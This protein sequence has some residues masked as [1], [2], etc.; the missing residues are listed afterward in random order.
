[1]DHSKIS[2]NR[3]RINVKLI[4]GTCTTLAITSGI[5]YPFFAEYVVLLGGDA[6]A[7]GLFFAVR[8]LFCA[9]ALIP[10]GYLADT[11]GRK[12][13]IV[14][15]TT[16]LGLVCFAYALVPSW[17][18]L[19]VLAAFEGLTYMYFPALT[20]LLM[21][22]APTGKVYETLATY[23]A[24]VHAPYTLMPVVGGVLR[25]AYGITGIR[26]GL[27]LFFFSALC[28]AF[29]RLRLRETVPR[30]RLPKLREVVGS[31][32]DIVPVLKKMHT[33]IRGLLLL[34]LAILTVGLCM[35]VNFAILYAT[36]VAGLSFTEWGLVYAFSSLAYVPAILLSKRVSGFPAHRLYPLCALMMAVSPLLFLKNSL[37][38]MLIAMVIA[39]LGGALAYSTERS[40]I[41]KTT[42]V[43]LRGRVESLMDL[44]FMLGGLVGSPIGGIIYLSSPQ[45]MLV[46]ASM[47]MIAGS[48]AG[49]F[50]LKRSF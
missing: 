23:I 32:V 35:F 45:L 19:V 15:F 2:P 41:I 12:K 14:S 25:D 37:F 48:A 44:S 49:Y 20:A 27:L 10:G 6:K 33:A 9:L 50:V 42:R 18:M 40:V 17:E 11:L 47:L 43:E 16:M 34:R 28:A 24:A 5:V 22:S 26:M 31:Y 1:M 7:V 3:L 8:S 39:G 38:L 21:D 30:I 46:T 13:M 29:V 36:R 4:L